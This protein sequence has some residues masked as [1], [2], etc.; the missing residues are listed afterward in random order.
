MVENPA[1][2]SLPFSDGEKSGDVKPAHLKSIA[3]KFMLIFVRVSSTLVRQLDTTGANP[4]VY[5]SLLSKQF[6]R[7]PVL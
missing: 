4:V 1:H 5:E 2:S 6:C 3:G 7:F